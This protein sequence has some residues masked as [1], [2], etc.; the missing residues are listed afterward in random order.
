[1]SVIDV[2]A[3]DCYVIFLLF[4][5]YYSLLFFL[6]F[7]RLSPSLSLRALVTPSHIY[8]PITGVCSRLL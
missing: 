7:V 4:F 5:S 6:S 2:I 8:G 1:M 3:R